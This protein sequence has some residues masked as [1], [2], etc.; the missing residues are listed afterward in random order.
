MSYS[1]VFIKKKKKKKKI[2]IHVTFADHIPATTILAGMNALVLVTT[3]A[4]YVRR[5]ALQS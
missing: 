1:N 2:R 4:T 5:P 3:F